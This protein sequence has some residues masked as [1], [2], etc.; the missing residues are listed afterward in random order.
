M[1]ITNTHN[2]HLQ[3]ILQNAQNAVWLYSVARVLQDTRRPALFTATPVIKNEVL[4][5][6]VCRMNPSLVQ[7]LSQML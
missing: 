5:H 4:E 6:V 1:S 7:E 2:D 3:T